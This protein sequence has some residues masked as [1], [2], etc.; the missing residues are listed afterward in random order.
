MLLKK[1]LYNGLA[2]IYA[3]ICTLNV[4]SMIVKSLENSQLQI[5]RRN[6]ST[7]KWGGVQVV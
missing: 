4:N 5:K 1:P 7:V 3:T 6:N 2:I